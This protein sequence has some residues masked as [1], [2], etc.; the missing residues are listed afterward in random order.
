VPVHRRAS[1]QEFLHEDYKQRKTST[2][3]ALCNC[4]CWRSEQLVVLASFGPHT[5][6]LLSPFACSVLALGLKDN[7]NLTEK[8]RKKCE[9]GQWGNLKG[10]G[11]KHPS[12]KQERDRERG[13]N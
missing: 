13:R 4:Q 3:Q 7:N 12:T 10:V 6:P 1:K 9:R 5:L 8:R 11:D 2:E